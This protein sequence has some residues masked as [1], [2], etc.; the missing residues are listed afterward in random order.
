MLTVKIKESTLEYLGPLEE[1]F[2]HAQLS[3]LPEWYFAC[4]SFFYQDRL[5]FEIDSDVF[6]LG[7]HFYLWLE[8]WRQ[9]HQL[10]FLIYSYE[11][12]SGVGF[13]SDFYEP[14][15]V[16]ERRSAVWKFYSPLLDEAFPELAF[17]P[18][19][20]KHEELVNSFTQY[21]AY[22]ESIL[23]RTG[24]PFPMTVAKYVET[25]RLL[26]EFKQRMLVLCQ[27]KSLPHPV[28]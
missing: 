3:D 19:F 8:I 14:F 2:S 26:E 1:H 17:A 6:A 23:Q 4:M 5:L 13:P 21:L 28:I 24:A 10:N 16:F 20:L 22:S 7:V 27:A 12:S 25:Y 9:H 15:L 18:I 11:A